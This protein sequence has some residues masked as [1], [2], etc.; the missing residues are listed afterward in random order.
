MSQNLIIYTL[1]CMPPCPNNVTVAIVHQ[2]LNIYIVKLIFSHHNARKHHYL[3]ASV[4]IAEPARKYHVLQHLL[5][6]RQKTQKTQ[7]FSPPPPV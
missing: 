7:Y 5:V 6:P 2:N 3:H 4:I 1:L